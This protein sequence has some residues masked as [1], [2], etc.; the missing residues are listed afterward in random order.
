MTRSRPT[1]PRD[2]R[3]RALLVLALLSGLL[4]MHGLAAHAALPA[5]IAPHRT[6]LAASGT[7]TAS[8]VHGHARPPMPA[9]AP[10]PGPCGGGTDAGHDCATTLCAADTTV[11]TWTP[12][13]LPQVPGTPVDAPS[14][15]PD[16]GAPAQ[17]ACRA[18]PDL[19]E[20]QLLRV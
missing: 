4:A 13:A 3:S 1:Q 20:L 16:R 15:A 10:R 5:P 8:V 2:G 12:P 14:V 9:R 6:H 19:S 7:S 17:T 11:T 18:P